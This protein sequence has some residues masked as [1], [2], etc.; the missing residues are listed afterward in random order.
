MDSCD[1]FFIVKMLLG[2]IIS[3]M[4]CSSCYLV[5]YLHYFFEFDGDLISNVMQCTYKTL[6]WVDL[7][8]IIFD[9][10]KFFEGASQWSYL[11]LPVIDIDICFSCA[12]LKY[13]SKEHILYW[14][15]PISRAS[16][17]VL[18]ML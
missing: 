13:L 9:K 18:N 8:N 10:S 11:G 12:S 17:W 2:L 6:N 3:S 4:C 7:T 5:I 1:D 14:K 15:L 16:F